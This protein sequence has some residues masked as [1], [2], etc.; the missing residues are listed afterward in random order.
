MDAI[1]STRRQLE[2]LV[3]IA[4]VNKTTPV[5]AQKPAAHHAFEILLFVSV[6]QDTHVSVELTG[7]C[8]FV[9]K[10]VNRHIG[11]G[12]KSVEA[13]PE[14]A[15]FTFVIG[16]QRLGI[17]WQAGTHGIVNEVQDQPG[18]VASKAFAIEPLD[19]AKATRENALAALSIDVFERV[20]W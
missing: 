9:P 5:D 12:Q 3:K 11:E 2:H 20:A 6:D 4:I 13:N 1:V 7:T 8:Q 14:A 15:E 18:S 10:P 19:A 16:F 17:G